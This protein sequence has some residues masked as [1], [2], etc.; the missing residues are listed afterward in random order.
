MRPVVITPEIRDTVEALLR[1][2]LVQLLPAGG[3][4]AQVAGVVANELLGEIVA[5]VNGQP[6]HVHADTAEI[7]DTRP[8]KPA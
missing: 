6:V 5:T 2:R 8:D 7:V 1:S 4:I 3:T